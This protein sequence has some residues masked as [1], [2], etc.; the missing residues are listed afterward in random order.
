[1]GTK[2]SVKMLK[3]LAGLGNQND[4]FQTTTI[5]QLLE[6]KQKESVWI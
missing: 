5:K 6:Y 3:L 2:N 4:V 1:M